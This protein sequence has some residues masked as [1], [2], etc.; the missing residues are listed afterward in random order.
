MSLMSLC[1]HTREVFA[2]ICA[3]LLLAGCGSAAESPTSTSSAGLHSEKQ[4]RTA[5]GGSQSLGPQDFA[6]AIDTPG[7]VT[8]NVHIPYEGDI[9]GTDL[10]VPFDQLHEQIT[11]L[12]S[13]R[14]TPLAIYCRSG[15][16]SRIAAETLAE[17]GYH[18]VVELA[19]GM[20]AWQ[21]SGRPVVFR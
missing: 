5:S 9:A 19:G 1:L 2:A 17:L 6:D 16:M 21:Q 18:D 13:V 12:P 7:V 4:P 11:A 10:T 15:R 20:Q 8:I 14:S 3:V